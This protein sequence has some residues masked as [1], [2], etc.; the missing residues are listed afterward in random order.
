MAR[1]L[2]IS[3]SA[4]SDRG[5]RRDGNEDAFCTDPELGLCVVCDGMGGHRAGEI[6]SAL[7]VETIRHCLVE[8]ATSPPEPDGPEYETSCTEA[9]NRLA[10]AIRQANHVVLDR[11]HTDA[12]TRGMGTTVVAALIRNDVASIAHVGDSRLYLLREGVL[13]QLTQD[14]SVVEAPRGSG[15]LAAGPPA[16][17]PPR[18]FLTRAVGLEPCVAVELTETP[19]LPGDTLLLCSDGLTH[20]LAPQ[21][22]R[23]TISHAPDRQTAVDQLIDKANAAGGRDNTTVILVTVER[24]G[25]PTLWDHLRHRLFGT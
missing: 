7:A 17:A 23:D 9:A 3:M 22:I 15:D 12:A 24:G 16:Q 10:Q 1:S 5:L 19:L 13:H 14:H 2:T 25:P 21:E 6:A 4:R 8:A 18:R 11:A 20:D